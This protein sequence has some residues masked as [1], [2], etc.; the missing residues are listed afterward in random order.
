MK[1]VMIV[2]ERKYNKKIRT[3]AYCRVTTVEE[4]LLSLENQINYYEKMI[5]EKSNIKLISESFPA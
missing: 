2:G 3:I 4:Q 5:N 1:S